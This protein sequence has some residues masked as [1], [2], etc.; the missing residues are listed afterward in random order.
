MS[1]LLEK[2]KVVEEMF[3]NSCQMC[4]DLSLSSESEENVMTG[5]GEDAPCTLP[6]F[7]MTSQD[8]D[9]SEV[10]S[11]WT[12]VGNRKKNKKTLT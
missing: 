1:E 2:E 12:Y 7:I 5:A 10:E 3:D 11:Q 9:L 4:Q 8:R 6:E